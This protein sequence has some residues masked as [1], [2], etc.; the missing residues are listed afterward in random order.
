MEMLRRGLE[1]LGKLNTIKEAERVG[2]ERT[3]Q[4]ELL[5]SGA[6]SSSRSDPGQGPAFDP[7]PTGLGNFDLMNPFF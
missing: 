3:K 1:S 2:K 5:P 4:D 7:G 6:A